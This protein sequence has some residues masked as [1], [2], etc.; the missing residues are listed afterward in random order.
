MALVCGTHLP[1]AASIVGRATPGAVAKTCA[2]AHC[3]GRGHEEWECPALFAAVH[4]E[5]MPGFL[6]DGTR[7]ATA[8]GADGSITP[9][10][11]LRWMHMQRQGF[12][13]RPSSAGRRRGG[14]R[15]REAAD[16]GAGV[17]DCVVTGVAREEPEPERADEGAGGVRVQECAGLGHTAGRGGDGGPAVGMVRAG[18]EFHCEVCRRQGDQWACFDAGCK[19][20]ESGP[21]NALEHKRLSALVRSA[22]R[23]RASAKATRRE[24]AGCKEGGDAGKR[25]GG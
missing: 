6:R 2:C 18:D 12:F 25:G 8:W 1:S 7:D 14:T 4:G 17:G 10:T 13:W 16:A 11:A 19:A 24:G 15:A 22:Q 9:A 23:A 20:S 21:W 5:R 3:G